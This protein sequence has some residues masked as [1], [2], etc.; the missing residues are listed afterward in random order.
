MS[1]TDSQNWQIVV[2]IITICHSFHYQV[3]MFT[4]YFLQCKNPLMVCIHKKKNMH[5]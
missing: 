2:T 1:L 4:T 3:V 5:V